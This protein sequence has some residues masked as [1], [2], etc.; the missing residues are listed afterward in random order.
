[1]SGKRSADVSEC[2]FASEARSKK[3]LAWCEIG[4]LLSIMT[5]FTFEFIND[6]QCGFLLTL[7]LYYIKGVA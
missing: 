5:I 6:M 3:D 4:F 2:V 7:G 1:M